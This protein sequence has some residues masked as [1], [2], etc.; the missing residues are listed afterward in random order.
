MGCSG[1]SQEC[2][3]HQ[4]FAAASFLTQ[5]LGPS[6]PPSLGSAGRV[7]SVRENVICPQP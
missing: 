6:I 7:V 1:P 2:Q 4:L 3:D 5:L